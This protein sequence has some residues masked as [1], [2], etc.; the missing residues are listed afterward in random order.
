MGDL[1]GAG[2]TGDLAEGPYV[3]CDAFG[4]KS[5]TVGGKTVKA[6]TPILYYR[7]NTSSKSL[8]ETSALTGTGIYDYRDNTLLVGLGKLGDVMTTHPLWGSVE[9]F[10]EYIKDPKVEAIPWPY[11]P[12]SY[13]LISAGA[14]GLYGNADITNFGN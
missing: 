4:V 2:N 8:T 6:G 3:I 13:I 11:R 1:F 10:Y 9:D 14:D 12:D 7:A 5:I